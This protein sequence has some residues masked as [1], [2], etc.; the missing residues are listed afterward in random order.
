MTPIFGGE[1]KDAP[2]LAGGE[3]LY[4]EPHWARQSPDRKYFLDWAWD[5]KLPHDKYILPRF[6]IYLGRLGGGPVRV[7]APD[8]EEYLAWAPDSRKFAYSR[9]L[10]Y[11]SLKGGLISSPIQIVTVGI[12]GAGEK[13]ILEKP[14]PQIWRVLDWSPD[15]KKLLVEHRTTVD[16]LRAS[17]RL[18]ELDLVSAETKGGRKPFDRGRS[19]D[20]QDDDRMKTVMDDSSRWVLDG[21]YSP[22]GKTIAALI[23]PM[24]ARIQGSKYPG[25]DLATIDV[26]TQRQQ[27]VVRYPGEKLWAP[28]CWSPDG[29]EIL[30]SRTLKPDDRREDQGPGE[31][32]WGIWAIRPDGTN[33]RF[34][35]TGWCADW[36]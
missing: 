6:M 2:G 27:T 30:F 14:F 16:M 11:P 13:I 3:T 17:S 18:Y 29:K 15:G 9:S 12:D 1:L 8:C 20:Q 28:L 36:R 21:K 25:A 22:D 19:D 24:R 33:A 5:V 31:P 4:R 34:I 10:Q 35:T 23:E 7:I 32:G 26:S